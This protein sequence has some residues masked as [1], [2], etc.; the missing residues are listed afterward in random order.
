MT[1]AAD[2]GRTW[3]YRFYDEGGLITFDRYPE[4]VNGRLDS[5]ESAWRAADLFK[6]E[7]GIAVT[8]IERKS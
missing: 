3:E 6:T 5:D 4:G 1:Q 2:F 8:R 7:H